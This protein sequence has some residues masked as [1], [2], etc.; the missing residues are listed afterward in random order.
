ML[1]GTAAQSCREE[2]DLLKKRACV[3]RFSFLVID[4]CKVRSFG[5]FDLWSLDSFWERDGY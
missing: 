4:M 5:R 1:P 3:P 2:V